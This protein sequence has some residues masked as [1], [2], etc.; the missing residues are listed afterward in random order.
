M[1][2]DFATPNPTLAPDTTHQGFTVISCEPVREIGG[3]AYIMR[4]DN[5]GARLMWLA[6][7]DTNRSFA[8]A[9]KTPPANHT[10]VFHILEHSVLCGSK[11]FPVKEP[12]VTLLKTSMQTFLNALTFPDKTMYPVASTNVA[13]LENLMDV[14]LDAVLHPAIYE[15]PRIFEQEGWHFELKDG[16]LVYNGVVFNEM[17][18][19]LSDPED[20]L[21]NELSAQLFPDTAYR[22]IS[23]GDP[24]HIP[25]LTYEEFIDTHARHYNLPNSY[26]ILYGDLDIER[27][28]A[29]IN[30]R[31]EG[32]D[33][34]SVGA[35]NPLG[36]QAPVTPPTHR[37]E[38][39]TAPDNACV[40]LSYVIS[41]TPERLLVFAADIL[42]DMLAGSNEAPLKRR[43][44]E[45]GLGDD[46]SI[47]VIDSELQPQLMFML[48]GA[49]EGVAERFRTL[50]EEVCLEL[51]NEGLP[52]ERLGASLAQM[53]FNLREGDWGGYPD[54]IALSMQAMASW[55]YDDERPLDFIR[56]EEELEQ[57]KGGI[58]EGLFENLLKRFILDST[59]N[60]LVD[61][62][63]T[64]T[65]TT[66]GQRAALDARLEEL[67]Q[68][69]LDAIEREVA[70]L[71]EEQEAPDSPEA[72]ATLPQ[73]RLADVGKAAPE[74]PLT[75]DTTH[76][77]P[78]LVH[79]LNTHGILYA[80]LYF[81]LSHL[82]FDEYRYMPL[83]CELLG[84]LDTTEHTALELDT[85]TQANLGRLNFFTE[86]YHPDCNTDDVRPRF[87]VGVS[88]LA[89]KIDML[90]GIVSE[91]CTHTLFT[92][93]N[94]MRDL[95]TQR[96]IV[97]EQ[98]F[99]NSGHT[100]ALSR[101]AS[102]SSRSALATQQ[103]I[104]VD[105]YLF[106]KGLLDSWDE[107]AEDIAATFAGLCKRIFCANTLTVSL[108]GP[109]ELRERFWETGGTDWFVPVDDEAVA[110]RFSIP[111]PVIKNEAFCTPANVCFVAEGSTD[112]AQDI[113]DDGSWQVAS[114]VLTL[115][116]LWNEVRV[117]GGAYG[118]GFKHF[119]TGLRVFWSYRDPNTVSTLT[120]FEDAFSWLNDWNPSETELEGYIVS[121]VAGHDA[122]VKPRALA[123]RQD[124][125]FFSDR[126]SDWRDQLRNEMLATTADTI[127]AFAPALE[128][129]THNHAIC[130]FGSR[131]IIERSQLD[132][133]VIDLM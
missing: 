83:L 33:N 16:Q 32:A 45:E 2:T 126:P 13:D 107:R 39:A 86:N 114:R 127:R 14:Y 124:T 36:T 30:E 72:L 56:Y 120:R 125:A 12:F 19:A 31:F 87:V 69:E 103:L 94:R 50:V 58:S 60:A 67:S 99:N 110:P 101:I 76:V 82:S 71:R 38:M 121:T 29:F 100:A 44:L 78:T 90:S 5:T 122:P 57:L 111:G 68:D 28:L 64:D 96:R 7:A 49:K 133:T 70:A 35:P 11:R 1:T 37:L 85:L 117:K 102:Y 65:N 132:L 118:C 40:G 73:L 26:T 18:G 108:T 115:D 4:H 55:L 112:L 8:I 52:H 79:D 59:H 130:I 91:M 20:V 10:G 113:K 123:R 119:T 116:Y 46:L 62:L 89:D 23:G 105:H 109:V 47:Q 51:V 63:P 131:E 25:E 22:W 77:V 88:V 15:R 9:F 66:S 93:T 34:R 41:D 43:V 84:Q 104:G 48:R 6:C 128:D 75:Y 97:L 24:N 61:L 98:S 17:C 27:E 42:A 3:C 74:T 81:D 53:E 80:Y 95:F 92:N 21:F 106:L 54:G 129:I